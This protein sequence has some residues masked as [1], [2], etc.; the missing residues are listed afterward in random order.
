M[1]LHQVW[2]DQ[3]GVTKRE[4]HPTGDAASKRCTQLIRPA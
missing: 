3:D 4:F 2:Y 1:N